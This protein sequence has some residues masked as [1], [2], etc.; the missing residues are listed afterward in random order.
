MKSNKMRGKRPYNLKDEYTHQK[1]KC[2]QRT[3]KSVAKY[4]MRIL[5]YNNSRIK[6][7]TYKPDI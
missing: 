2:C 1:K 5:K 6:P 4:F 3:E 7:Q